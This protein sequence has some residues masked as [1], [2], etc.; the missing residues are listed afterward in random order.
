MSAEPAGHNYGPITLVSQIVGQ[1]K[2]SVEI[3]AKLDR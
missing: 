3:V 1:K 2:S